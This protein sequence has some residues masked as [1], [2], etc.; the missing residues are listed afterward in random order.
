MR[1][2]VTRIEDIVKITGELIV[3]KNALAH[4]VQSLD[5]QQN[6][7]RDL[8]DLNTRFNRL[9][10]QLLRSV[11]ATRVLPLQRVFQ[12]FPRLVR[13]IATRLNKPVRLLTEGEATEA[14]KVIVEALF[15]PILHVLRNAIDHG[16]EPAAQRQGRRQARYR[17][18]RPARTPRRRSGRH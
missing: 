17:H 1:V 7:S 8:Q 14:D 9:T 4:I 16:I 13:E 10:A 6:L 18:R 5:S 11:L 15:E 2:D 12:R 3:A